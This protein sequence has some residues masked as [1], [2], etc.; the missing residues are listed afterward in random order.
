MVRSMMG[1]KKEKYIIKNGV[2]LEKSLTITTAKYGSQWSSS[3][4]R[5]LE[6]RS[7]YIYFYGS[8]YN[9][10]SGIVIQP[11]IV[12]S[13][14]SKLIVEADIKYNGSYHP[15]VIVGTTW[16]NTA[17]WLWET[18][19]PTAEGYK[20]C[21]NP[22]PTPTTYFEFNIIGVR[23]IYLFVGFASID[24]PDRGCVVNLYNVYLK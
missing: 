24:N 22:N 14:F 18:M 5:T 11:V 23:N 15:G 7:G 6:F 9:R 16:G 10:S 4:N 17:N 8:C 3:D 19:Q 12:N 21:S 20:Y 1:R 2:L 13:G